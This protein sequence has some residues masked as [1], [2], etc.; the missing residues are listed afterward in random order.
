MPYETFFRTKHIWRLALRTTQSLTFLWIK[1]SL[2]QHKTG[3]LQFLVLMIVPQNKIHWIGGRT[4][5]F[6]L[7]V[8]FFY[9]I[10]LFLSVQVKTWILNKLFV[11]SD[12]LFCSLITWTEKYLSHLF[13]SKLVEEYKIISINWDK[14]CLSQ[15]MSKLKEATCL[16]N[17]K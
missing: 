7:T 12:F 4:Q 11:L 16:V 1:L 9:R 6:F 17:F 14:L 15:D 13:W 8:F 5:L 3:V 10:L 2:S